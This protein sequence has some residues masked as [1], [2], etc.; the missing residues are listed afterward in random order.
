MHHHTTCQDE[1]GEGGDVTRPRGRDSQ[2][3]VSLLAMFDDIAD[4]AA[5]KQRM[6][7][8]DCMVEC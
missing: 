4:L 1:F 6:S 2:D 7:I 8:D 5:R 3:T